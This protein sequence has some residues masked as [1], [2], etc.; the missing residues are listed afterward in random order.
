MLRYFKM[1]LLSERTHVVLFILTKEKVS[2][3]RATWR[4]YDLL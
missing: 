1:T 4:I 3:A 2:V